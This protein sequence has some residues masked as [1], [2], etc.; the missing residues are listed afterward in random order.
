MVNKIISMSVWGDNPRYIVG[1]RRQVEL[2]KEFY[3][4]WKVRIYVDDKSKLADLDVELIEVTDGSYG[5][6]WRFEPMFEDENNIV[7]VRDSD[8]RI[9]IREQ[10]AVNEWLES[11]KKFHTFKDHE[12]HYEFMIIGCAFGYKGKLPK[13]AHDQMKNYIKN[14][15][16]YTGD[17]LYLQEVIWPLVKD[18]AIVHSMHE[19]WFGE[20]RKQ[21]DNKYSFCGNGYTE[22]D[23]PLY[24]PRFKDFKGWDQENIPAHTK[25]DKGTFK[26]KKGIL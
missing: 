25:F 5:M 10:M 8:S 26:P 14:R 9:T 3:P 18:D 2:A 12:A 23:L 21:L 20:T 11:D 7:M 16:F 24:P 1:A 15:G 13:E 17:Q 19:G 6:Y 4:D 22:N